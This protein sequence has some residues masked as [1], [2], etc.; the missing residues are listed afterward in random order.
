MPAT[1]ALIPGNMCDARLWDGDNSLLR[2]ALSQ[3]GW[4]L[5]DADMALDDTI[6]AMAARVLADCDGPLLPIGFS[7]GAIIAL[8]MARQAPERIIAAALFGLNAG[9]D[10][11][12]RS[13]ARIRQQAEVRSGGL[14]RVIIEELKP[15]YLA[16]CNRGDSTLLALLRDMGMALGPVVFIA[17]S[18]ALRL[19]PDLRGVLDTLRVPVLL[20][21][22]KEDALCPP[23]WHEDWARQLE[24]VRNI[25][26][27]NTGHMLPLENSAAFTNAIVRWIDDKGL[28]K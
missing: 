19:R 11:P 14:E 15:N 7:M 17:Q 27:D 16:R 21:C 6:S 28:M 25:V 18:E 24:D 8:E 10:L 3:Y 5:H 12:E 4:A 2:N 1:I 20:G 13:A 9:A 23:Q 26:F 22:G